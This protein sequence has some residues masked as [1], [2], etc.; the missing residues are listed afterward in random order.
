MERFNETVS[1]LISC[2]IIIITVLVISIYSFYIYNIQT[3]DETVITIP[4][5]SENKFYLYH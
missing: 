1:C 5:K 4:S 3:L 2:I